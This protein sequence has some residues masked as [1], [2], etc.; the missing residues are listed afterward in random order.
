MKNAFKL[1]ATAFILTT[2]LSSMTCRKKT[3]HGIVHVYDSTGAPLPDAKI[4]VSHPL[5]IETRVVTED[6]VTRID[7][8]YYSRAANPTFT[9]LTDSYGEARFE[10][11][12]PVVYT[13]RADHPVI[14]DRYVLGVLILSEEGS[15]D[16]ETLIFK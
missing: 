8:T 10:F 11:K 9:A 6:G 12:L 3:V 1:L 16:E 14:P 7:T 4:L 15:T 5:E 13:V 2:I